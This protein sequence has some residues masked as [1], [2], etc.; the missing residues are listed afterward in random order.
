MDN[1]CEKFRDMMLDYV[2]NGS[3]EEP[4]AH[5]SECEACREE[6]EECKKMLASVK[7]AA[8]IPP[9]DL[10][11]KVMLA[12]ATDAKMRRRRLIG[13]LTAAAA[14]F[15]VC[16]GIGIALLASGG[17]KAFDAEMDVNMSGGANA[18]MAEDQNGSG[19]PGASEDKVLNDMESPEENGDEGG[20]G[21][22]IDIH[23]SEAEDVA[24][25]L[26]NEHGYESVI[27][28]VL[29]GT[30]AGTALERICDEFE[31]D[32]LEEGL[33][34]FDA[35][36]AQV[37]ACRIEELAGEMKVYFNAYSDSAS[38]DIAAVYVSE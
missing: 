36:N 16:A 22:T 25:T 20:Y 29:K 1:N 6:L 28:F 17:F 34:V 37:F 18:P 2:E 26:E 33:Y 12:V 5:L 14:V 8:P 24:A 3:S 10:K 15:V 32:E 7:N 13:H 31:A 30:D 9:A 19:R 11:K 4:E 38:P 21:A 35:A 27:V 23:E